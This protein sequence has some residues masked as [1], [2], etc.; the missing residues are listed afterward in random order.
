MAMLAL[1][2]PMMTITWVW[3][4]WIMKSTSTRR[5]AFHQM[6]QP[7]KSRSSATLATSTIL[8]RY[9][10]S[11]LLFQIHRKVCLREHLKKV[12]V[13]VCVCACMLRSAWVCVCLSELC[14]CVCVCLCLYVCLC[15]CLS[16]CVSVSVCVCLCE[17]R[18]WVYVHVCLSVYLSVCLSVS[19]SVCL[20]TCIWLLLVFLCVY[21]HYSTWA[22]CVCVVCP[23]LGSHI[24][25]MSLHLLSLYFFQ[26]NLVISAFGNTYQIYSTSLSY[27]KYCATCGNNAWFQWR[28]KVEQ[29]TDSLEL[30]QETP[31]NTGSVNA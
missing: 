22:C 28:I 23:R 29:P 16:L 25:S 17:L 10:Y 27:L 12:C 1:K 30:E 7:I 13:C 20:S 2:A 11:C 8:R 19:L 14:T 24:L 6:I 31:C 21:A 5:Q 9:V 4:S 26:C 3:Q 15:V 18:V